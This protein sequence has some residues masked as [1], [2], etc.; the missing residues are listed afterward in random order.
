M[1]IEARA[2]G[3]LHVFFLSPSRERNQQHAVATRGPDATRD[4]VAVHER[5][6]DVEQHD[7]G[8]ELV[9]DGKCFGTAVNRSHG[10]LSERSSMPSMS[11]ASWLSSTTSTRQ[12]GNVPKTLASLPI[13]PL[14][15]ERVEGALRTWCPGRRPSL[16]AD[17]RAAVRGDQASHER[18]SNP[19]AALRPSIERFTCVN[20]SN[21]AERFSGANPDSVVAHGHHGSRRP[22]SQRRS[23]CGHQDR[24]IWR[25]C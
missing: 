12:P 22:D 21:T 14:I 4:L 15:G 3:A 20:M 9:D 7:L 10:R 19:Q 1:M 13:R 18:Q 16:L 24:C 2:L 8:I 11:P 6:A 25:R 5:H 23:R 17:D